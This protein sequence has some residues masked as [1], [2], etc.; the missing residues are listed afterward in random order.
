MAKKSDQGRL[1][2]P[3][4]PSM[5]MTKFEIIQT[6]QNMAALVSRAALAG[7]LGQTFGGARDLYEI[8]GWKKNLVFQ[9]YLE[10]YDRNGM[11]ARVVDA[12]SDESWRLPPVLLDGEMRGDDEN[13]GK[14]TPFLAAWDEFAERLDLWAFFNE[15]DTSLGISR[16]AI[17]LLGV[18]GKETGKYSM[19]LTKASDVAYV[20]VYDEGQAAISTTDRSTDSPRYGMPVLYQVTFEDGGHSVPVHHSRVLHCK[21]GRGRSRVYGIPRLKKSY[22]YLSDL[23]KVVG[24]SSEA[25][26]LLI[27]KG[28]ILT[29]QEGKNFPVAGSPEYQTMQ[30]EIT[31]WEHQLRRVMRLKGVDATDLGAQVVDGKAQHDLLITDI[32]GTNG[33]PQRVLVGS[34]RGELASSQDDSNWAG[35]VGARQ[36]QTCT[37]WVK[38]FA[39][40]MI[41]LG[42]LPAASGKL[43]LDWPAL[44]KLTDADMATIANTVADAIVK[45]TNGAP[46][47]AIDIESYIKKYFKHL[48]PANAVKQVAPLVRKKIDQI[49][50]GGKNGNNGANLEGEQETQLIETA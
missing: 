25:F 15:L 22:N 11:A 36:T 5:K 8:L 46:E 27:R 23:E 4:M 26:W 31:E 18:R 30:D 3:P 34:E 2:L 19:P 43:S 32:A 49:K 24:S 28:L 33:M 20:Q 29:A 40:R 44:F 50:A 42:V 38:D 17:I 39:K 48:L 12:L 47:S 37:K 16:Y 10:M 9:D 7:T 35:V 14:L 1:G 6:Y 13:R 41:A 21:E 45:V